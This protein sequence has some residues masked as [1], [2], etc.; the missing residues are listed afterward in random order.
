VA[1][2]QAAVTDCMRAKVGVEVVVTCGE[3]NAASTQMIEAFIDKLGWAGCAVGKG[4]AAT[5][6]LS[7]SS[8]GIFLLIFPVAIN[9]EL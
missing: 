1:S 6:K 9:L 3:T 7:F 2:W 5:K 4:G 8:M